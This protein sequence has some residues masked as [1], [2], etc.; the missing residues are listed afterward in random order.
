MCV[1][2]GG[3]CDQGALFRG[4]GFFCDV[5]GGGGVKIKNF[6]GQ[7]GGGHIF[8]QAWR[9]GGVGARWGQM[10]SIGFCFH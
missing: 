2:G 9:G 5:L 8:H 10:Y 4:V 7:V 6:L 3:V 1:A